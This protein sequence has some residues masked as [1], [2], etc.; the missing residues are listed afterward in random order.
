MEA[1]EKEMRLAKSTSLD[2]QMK[3]QKTF[4]PSEQEQNAQK[5]MTAK[6]PQLSIDRLYV[7]WLP[8][9]NKFEVEIDKL[10]LLPVTKFTYFKELNFHFFQELLK[11]IKDK[12]KLTR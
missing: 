4:Q 6:L 10:E 8:F 2:Q 3:F 11:R 7:S 12:S 5:T 1:D 9:W